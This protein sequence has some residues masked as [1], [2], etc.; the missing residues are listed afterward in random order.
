MQEYQRKT[1]F[2][3]IRPPSCSGADVS[4]GGNTAKYT[5]SKRGNYDQW[6]KTT[7][8]ETMRAQIVPEELVKTIPE[9]TILKSGKGV[10]RFNPRHHTTRD[11]A[12]TP[13]TFVLS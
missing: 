9:E 2:T 4:R 10:L 5:R 6:L 3:T 13:Y 11:N 7:L 12:T 8:E 1:N